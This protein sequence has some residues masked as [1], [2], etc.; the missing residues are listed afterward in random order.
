MQEAGGYTAIK[1]SIR[2]IGLKEPLVVYKDKDAYFLCDGYNRLTAINELSDRD[3]LPASVDVKS[4]RCILIPKD[5]KN[6]IRY[7]TDIRQD[8]EPSLK[9]EC[10]KKLFDRGVTRKDIAKMCGYSTNT[11]R[12]WLLVS[13]LIKPLQDLMDAGKLPVDAAI[14]ISP[15]T[16]AG[17][18][19]LLNKIKDWKTIRRDEIRSLVASF[20]NKHYRL[21]KE[22]R[23]EL[24]KKLKVE[25]PKEKQSVSEK[26]TLTKS[27]HKFT[28]ERDYIE[29]ETR[30]LR[31]KTRKLVAWI[32]RI[33]RAQEVKHYIQSNHKD[34]YNDLHNIVEV[35]L[36]R[37]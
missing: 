34:A 22:E 21:S 1:E 2:N 17:Q 37:K 31:T 9:A 14:P 33:F 11:I 26:K 10:I 3:Q 6:I 24:G 5:T 16:E 28:I 12:N 35:E 20:S 4:I 7:M 23:V 8:L 19:H 29:T 30:L 36:G 27:L 32:E 15:L 13:R 25:S 18:H